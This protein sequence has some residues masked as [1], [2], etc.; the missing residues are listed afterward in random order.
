MPSSES[1]N[2][3]WNNDAIARLLTDTGMIAQIHIRQT[4]RHTDRQTERQ[5]DR[6]TD[7]QRERQRESYQ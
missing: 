1:C 3:G 4:Y 5:T 7:I 2:L 6:Q